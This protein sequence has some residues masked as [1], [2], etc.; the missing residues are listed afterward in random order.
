[1]EQQPD[2]AE[3]P[4]KALHRKMQS[5][6]RHERELARLDALRIDEL[7]RIERW[8][9]DVSAGERRRITELR[10]EI[11]AWAKDQRTDRVKSWKTPWG[12]VSTNENSVGRVVIDDDAAAREWASA[13]GVLNPPKPAPEPTID[14]AALRKLTHIED[15]KLIDPTGAPV[16]GVHVEGAGSIGVSIKTDGTP[17]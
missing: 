4:R 14:V 15:G 10:L 11:E 8:F 6:D 7:D 2:E 3:D 12:T 9:D 17:R 13:H 5:L 16:P 1:M